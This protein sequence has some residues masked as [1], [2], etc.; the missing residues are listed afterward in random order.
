M[1]QWTLV[2]MSAA[3]FSGAYALSFAGNNAGGTIFSAAAIFALIF[4]FLAKFKRF[5]GLGIEAELWE[6]KMEE[7]E[8]LI[9]RLRTLALSSYRPIAQLVAKT[10]RPLSKGLSRREMHDVT[11]ALSSHMKSYKGIEPHE[12]NEVLRPLYLRVESEICSV[13]AGGIR[14]CLVMNANPL[15]KEA[16]QI[17][18]PIEGD[19][20][21]K[22]NDLNEGLRQLND[23]GKH[24]QTIVASENAGRRSATLRDTIETSLLLTAEQRIQLR[25]LLR[26]HLED[27]R[28]YEDHRS[29]RDLELWC[30]RDL[31]QERNLVVSSIRPDTRYD[32]LSI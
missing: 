27:L 30:S 28:Y 1:Q 32:D 22:M 13:I 10:G 11:E 20:I 18:S 14:T 25:N 2:G 19:N 17:P 12:I 7:A 21:R 15:R 31:V 8:Q 16:G 5:K 3:L 9:G 26:D 29:H 6:E 23:F 24:L 4:A